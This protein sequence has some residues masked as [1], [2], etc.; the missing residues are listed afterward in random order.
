M[1]VYLTSHRCLSINWT[2][3][4][5]LDEEIEKGFTR[6]ETSSINLKITLLEVS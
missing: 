3:S 1:K 6:N 5:H 2:Y 4:K